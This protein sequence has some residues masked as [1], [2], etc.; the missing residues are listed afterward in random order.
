MF[1]KGVKHLFRN[2]AVLKMKRDVCDQSQ[3]SSLFW[4]NITHHNV[5]VLIIWAMFFAPEQFFLFSTEMTKVITFKLFIFSSLSQL[6]DQNVWVFL[7][8]NDSATFWKRYRC[9]PAE[10]VFPQSSG[11]YSASQHLLPEP[12]RY[13]TH[14]L[15]LNLLLYQFCSWFCYSAEHLGYIQNCSAENTRSTFRAC[16][17]PH[18]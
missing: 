14:R 9:E 7:R 11:F 5:W 18:C 17:S 6:G 2:V 1:C 3:T 8:A 4:C 12:C 13:M 16:P 10:G 15:P